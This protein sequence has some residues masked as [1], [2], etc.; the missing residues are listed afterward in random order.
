MAHDTEPSADGGTTTPVR[1]L[2]IRDGERVEADDRVVREETVVLVVGG[3]RLLRVQCL[4]EAVEDLAIGLL[5]TS[6]LLE[7]G[8]P[9]PDVAYDAAAHRVTAALDVPEEQ[10]AALEASMTLGSGCGAAL[11]PT[12][13]FDPFDCSRKLDTAFAVETG[14]IQ[15][16]MTAF[17]ARSELFRQT[18]GVHSA[19]ICHGEQVVAFADD[20]GR[21]NAFDKVIG[22]CRRQGIDLI[23]KLALVTGRLSRE[24]VAK[25]VPVSLPVLVSRG[26]PTDAGIDLA[27]LA[28]LTLIGFARARRLNVYTAPWRLAPPVA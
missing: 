15:R 4:P 22:A 5:A 6:G 18:G 2:R 24:L 14:V 7:P 1:V 27:R 25:A 8:A 19:A 23:D 16:A 20:I 21:H 3:R 12:G 11:S 17:V 26:A 10:I 13:Q 28:N 9:V